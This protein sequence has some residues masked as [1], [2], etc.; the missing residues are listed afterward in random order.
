[1]FAFFISVILLAATGE[2]AGGGFTEFYDKYLNYPGFEAW[3][4]INLAIFVALLI[5]IAQKKLGPKF[6]A[7]REAIRAELIKAEEEKQA[8]L[9]KLTSAEARLASLDMEKAAS[10]IVNIVTE[11]GRPE[12]LK[13]A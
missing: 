4:F 3:K 1:M 8:A 11:T 12:A 10:E 7:R 5:Y 9:A 6:I 13:P 2:Q